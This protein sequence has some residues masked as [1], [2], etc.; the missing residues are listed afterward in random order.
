MLVLSLV[1]ISLAFGLRSAPA[2]AQQTDFPAE[3]EVPGPT[4]NTVENFAGS[5][6]GPPASDRV[7]SIFSVR[8]IAVE[9]TARSASKARDIA[10]ANGLEQAFAAL[11]EKLVAPENAATVPPLEAKDL[12]ELVSG[13]D[14]IDERSSQLQ[15]FATLNVSF[16]P[17]RVRSLFGEWGI[18]YAELNTRPLLVLPLMATNGVDLL[19]EKENAWADAWRSKWPRGSLITYRLPEFSMKDV[20]LISARAVRLSE[21]ESLEAAARNYGAS[22]TLI[23]DARLAIPGEVTDDAFDTAEPSEVFGDL[24]PVAP[25][26]AVTRPETANEQLKTYH[27][28]IKR[29]LV[30]NLDIQFHQRQLAD[31][32]DSAFFIRAIDR[33][34]Q[35]LS[36]EWKRGVLIEFGREE[37]LDILVPFDSVGEWRARLGALTAL[38]V[39]KTHMVSRLAIGQGLVNVTYFGGR[40]QFEKALS[41]VGFSLDQVETLALV[42]LVPISVESNNESIGEGEPTDASPRLVDPLEQINRAVTRPSFEIPARDDQV[43]Q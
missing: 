30:P 21:P 32:S 14:V 23:V 13:V 16:Y 11:V 26:K 4:D 2:I 25:D 39:V 35:R 27:F 6:N 43:R 37:K 9:A 36:A 17:E 19:W 28:T 8:D 31:E 42:R 15:Y 1:A 20:A 40:E 34:D 18:R 29:N 33:I 10:M 3:V 38:P 7:R 41:E 24:P 5:T 12:R 22:D